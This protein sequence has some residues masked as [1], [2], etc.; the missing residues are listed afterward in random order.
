MPPPL[1][2]AHRVIWLCLAF[3]LPL[4]F[5]AALRQN[6]SLPVQEPLGAPLAAPLPVLVRSSDTPD[7]LVNLRRDSTAAQLEI[8]VKKSLAVPSAVVRV[9]ANGRRSALGILNVPGL[10][11]FALPDTA[12]HPTIYITDEIHHANLQLI[13]L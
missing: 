11:R 9:S 3:V 10:Y 1:R 12:A 8:L 5:V 6:D 2:Q 4:A 7:F 13:Q